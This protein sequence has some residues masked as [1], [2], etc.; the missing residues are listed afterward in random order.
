MISIIS[1]GG[2]HDSITQYIN[3]KKKERNNLHGIQAEFTVYISNI[4]SS[5]RY[6]NLYGS[7][8]GFQ[9]INSG[10]P[11]ETRNDPIIIK[12]PKHDKNPGIHIGHSIS[13]QK[14][15]KNLESYASKNSYYKFL[16]E[17][18]IRYIVY[19]N[20]DDISLVS[21]SKF[22]ITR[23][24]R[25]DLRLAGISFIDRNLGLHSAPILKALIFGYKKEIDP[26]TKK[27]F[28]KSGMIHVLTVSGLHVGIIAVIFFS[29]INV[30]FFRKP[31]YYP[32][33][34]LT[35]IV[36]LIFYAELGGGAPP[37]YRA[38][39]MTALFLLA[40]A[41]SFSAHSLNTLAVSAM[42]LLLFNPDTLY[43]ISFQMSYS[44][45][46]G[47]ILIFPVLSR[48]YLPKN[49]WLKNAVSIIYLGISAQFLIVPI[50]LFHFGSTSMIS[51][52]SS[53]VAI[54]CTFLLISSFLVLMVVG[55]IHPSIHHW[56]VILIE[57]L[58]NLF[59]QS[60]NVFSLLPF[61]EI[62]NIAINSTE[63]IVILISL[64]LLIVFVHNGNPRYAILGLTGLCLQALYHTLCVL[65]DV[66]KI[67]AS[68][69][70]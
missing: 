63:T 57:R 28:V 12:I 32:I 60:A 35:L 9:L 64:I 13:F 16:K 67:K 1:L 45:V 36:V 17:R 10:D 3:S 68:S 66:L 55:W 30:I 56:I 37:V 39:L 14:I 26:T 8:S 6:I 11:S 29:I 31:K 48:N 19:L 18:G 41:Y 42:I 4:D 69:M 61:S 34:C 59:L 5:K 51:P 47:I 21:K 22:E 24:I 43:S 62:T 49:A 38:T 15:V 46:T 65:D 53:I 25:R 40:R 50:A 33:S 52:I 20:F 54:P 70:I 44:A 27:H 7:I 58:T 2:F 23:F